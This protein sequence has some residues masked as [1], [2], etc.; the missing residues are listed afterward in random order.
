MNDIL[1]NQQRMAEYAAHANDWGMIVALTFAVFNL[2]LLAFGSSLA[3]R[4]VVCFERRT[5]MAERALL[6]SEGSK[7]SKAA[8]PSDEQYL[9]RK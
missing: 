2:V 8:L 4:M 5:D 6:M 3:W 7:A 9:P 1:A